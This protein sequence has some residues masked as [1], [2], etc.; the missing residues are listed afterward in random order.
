MTKLFRSALLAVLLSVLA[1]S[2]RSENQASIQGTIIEKRGYIMTG[3]TVSARNNSIG[4]Q[5]ETTSDAAGAFWFGNVEPGR[6]VL[7]SECPGEDRILGSAVVDAGKT[8]RVELLA[9]PLPETGNGAVDKF[10]AS[11]SAQG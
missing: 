3:L 11:S 5:Y 7:S 9:L 6:Y 1:G 2:A 8:T 4:K 10:I